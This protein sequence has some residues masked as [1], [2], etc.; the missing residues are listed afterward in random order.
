MPLSLALTLCVVAAGDP[1][2]PE[3]KEAREARAAMVDR[4]MAEPTRPFLRSRGI[5]TYEDID[6]EPIEPV[7]EEGEA[8]AR[9]PAPRVQMV[10][11]DR[12][13]FD[14]WLF[15]GRGDDGSKREWLHHRL[16]IKVERAALRGR[17]RPSHVAKLR[18][19]GR[20]D[21]KRFH[22]RV[23]EMRAEFD[24]LRTDLG[25]GQQFLNRDLKPL[26]EEFQIGPFGDGSLFA[27]TLTKIEEETGASRPGK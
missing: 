21:I 5:I 17:L 25:R 2:G 27:K 12:E 7:D 8:A 1:P 18:L 24:G 6:R 23:E 4:I 19:A 13:N 15:G 10:C 26:T 22:D 16:D 9:V 11:L 3:S 20:G 14:R